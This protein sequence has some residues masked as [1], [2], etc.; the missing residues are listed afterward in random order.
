MAV[1]ILKNLRFIGGNF[2]PCLCGKKRAK[3]IVYTSI[4]IDDNLMVGTVE[5][6]DGAI[7]GL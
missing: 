7:A 5:A 3:G 4:Y 6:I 2:N 1:E